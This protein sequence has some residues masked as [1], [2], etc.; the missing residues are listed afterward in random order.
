[1]LNCDELRAV[2]I[3]WPE[4]A[5]VRRWCP[6]TRMPSRHCSSRLRQGTQVF[7]RQW[8]WTTH[9]VHSAHM[10]ADVGRLPEKLAERRRRT[11]AP[12]LTGDQQRDGTSRPTSRRASLTQTTGSERP[13]GGAFCRGRGSSLGREQRAS[14]VRPAGGAG[15]CR[16]L[17]VLRRWSWRG[18]GTLHG[19]RSLDYASVRWESCT[20]MAMASTGSRCWRGA[21]RVVWSCRPMRS[22]VSATGG[23]REAAATMFTALGLSST[24]H[25][26]LGVAS[27][28]AD[29]E[30]ELF[31]GRLSLSEHPWLAD[32]KVFEQRDLAWDGA[33]GAGA[34]GGAGGGQS[35][36]CWS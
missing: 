17:R 15:R 34:C 7:C 14:G 10:D 4:H 3:A 13:R 2:D 19:M 18:G 1:M 35:D 6:G 25:A 12:T 20:R 30:G 5:D 22:S 9:R 11:D 26:M 36:G 33:G 24:G 27:P 21:G 32:H 23:S 29:S 8:T 16:R 28:L 31:S